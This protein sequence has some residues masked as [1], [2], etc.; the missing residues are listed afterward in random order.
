MVDLSKIKPGD[1]VTIEAVVRDEPRSYSDGKYVSVKAGVECFSFPCRS[2]V[3]HTP[4]ALSVGDRVRVNG[5]EAAILAVHGGYAWVD[6][7]TSTH[8]GTWGLS[9]LER[10][11]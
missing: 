8:P 2:I 10:V 9:Q 11:G 5:A 1:T 7:G 4:K 3:S 6:L